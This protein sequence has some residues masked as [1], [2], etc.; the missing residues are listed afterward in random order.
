MMMKRTLLIAV[1]AIGLM[2]D[3]A[4]ALTLN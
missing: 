1:W 4:M 3:S 2:S